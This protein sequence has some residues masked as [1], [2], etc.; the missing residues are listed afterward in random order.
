[1]E[2]LSD[3]DVDEQ[4]VDNE[5]G[6]VDV[7]NDE[8]SLTPELPEPT[9]EEAKSVRV[10]LTIWQHYHSSLVTNVACVAYLCSPHP[11]IIAHSEDNVNKDPKNAIAVEQYI[12]RV[13]LPQT[14]SR[15]EDRT[16]ELVRMVDM[17]WFKREDFV[18]CHN[19][20]SRENIWSIA[21]LVDT[22]HTQVTQEVLLSLHRD[23]G[24]CGLHEA[25]EA[26]GYGQA[27]RH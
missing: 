24:S 12:E 5:L 4:E 2:K 8:V 10:A 25:S 9:D 15:E 17:F 26:L 27:E 6:L 16:V 1:L 13:I 19:Y 14:C 11:L 18:K 22:D 3:D 20:F 21:V 23:A 7:D